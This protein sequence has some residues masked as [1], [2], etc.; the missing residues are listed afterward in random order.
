MELDAGVK[1]ESRVEEL[2][3]LLEEGKEARNHIIESNQGLVA[4]RAFEIG[5]HYGI[6]EK[7]KQE[8]KI[9][10]SDLIQHGNMGLFRAIEKFNP[11]VGKFSTYATYWI[12]QS[13]RRAIEEESPDIRLP[14]YRVEELTKLRKIRNKF[15]GENEREPT[16]KE[17]AKLMGM[18]LPKFRELAMAE[19]QH[20]VSIDTNISDEDDSTLEAVIPDEDSQT[21]EQAVLGAL[22]DK[23]WIQLLRDELTDKEMQVLD[24][25]LGL[26]GRKLSVEEIAKVM[27]VDP[28]KVRSM[29]AKVVRKL[30]QSG[31]A[32]RLARTAGTKV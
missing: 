17:L 23:N 19:I 31:E 13:I 25:Q 26:S 15:L 1:S 32:K 14:E 7:E 30:A 5:R 12:D 29:H 28:K 10:V 11:D 3:S 24:W 18:P 8:G 2:N 4:S 21:P 27:N 16:E 22:T 20:A 6:S 9:T